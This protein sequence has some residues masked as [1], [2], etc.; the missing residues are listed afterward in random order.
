MDTARAGN[1]RDACWSPRW[2]QGKEPVEPYQL[3]T[4]RDVRQVLSGAF[5]WRRRML[6]RCVFL[7][8][9]KE[10]EMACGVDG[11]ISGLWF[12]VRLCSTD[13]RNF[14]PLTGDVLVRLW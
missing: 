11:S 7:P 13:A 8:I 9:G 1:V 4:S 6:L 3:T 14:K 10:S 5:V 2:E 12:P